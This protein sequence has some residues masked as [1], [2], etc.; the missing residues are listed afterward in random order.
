MILHSDEPDDVRDIIK[1][2]SQN[3]HL[4]FLIAFSL[5]I[6]FFSSLSLSLSIALS[7]GTLYLMVLCPPNDRLVRRTLEEAVT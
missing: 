5:S 6:S 1:S 7:F 2:Q 4:I 3:D